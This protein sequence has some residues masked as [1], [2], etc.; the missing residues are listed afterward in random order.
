MYEYETTIDPYPGYFKR[1]D[2]NS[3]DTGSNGLSSCK[4]AQ[5]FGIGGPY[6]WFFGGIDEIVTYSM[7]ED[8]IPVSLGT[9]WYEGQFERKR[10]DAS[11]GLGWIEPTG[12]KAGGHQ[13]IYRG[14]IEPLD[15]LVIRCWWGGV[16]DMLIKR[17]HEG[18]LLADDGDAHVQ[19]RV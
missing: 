5:H 17:S 14:Y 18:D 8:A 16:R 19:E 7:T 9:W 13:Y 4:T 2:P 12:P 10:Y 11:S 6:T 15:A 1:G 3:Q